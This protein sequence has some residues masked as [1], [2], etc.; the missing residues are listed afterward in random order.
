MILDHKRRE[1]GVIAAPWARDANGRAIPTR[2]EIQGTT[3][4]QVVD[5]RRPG[6][7]YPVVADPNLFS[8]MKC[9]GSVVAALVGVGVPA[10]KLVWLVKYVKRLGGPKEAAKLL[11]GA[12]SK[13]EKVKAI[14]KALGAKSGAAL[15]GLLLGIPGIRDNC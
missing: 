4:V 14:K 10:A 7:V 8:W 11:L 15:A 12:T 1:L 6:V 3:L 9:A 13:A 5:H 2:Y